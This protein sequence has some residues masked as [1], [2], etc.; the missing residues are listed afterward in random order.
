MKYLVEVSLKMRSGKVD[1][2]V[3]SLTVKKRPLMLGEK[4]DEEVK[5]C[6]KAVRE[7][8]GVITTAIAMASATAIV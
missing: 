6:I 5:H 4:L 8:G 1:I 7:G 3:T 2:S